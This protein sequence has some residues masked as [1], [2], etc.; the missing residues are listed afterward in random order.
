MGF[1][2]DDARRTPIRSLRLASDLPE[3]ERARLELLRTDGAT[4][5]ALVEARRNRRDA[6]YVAPAGRIDLC[7]VP[8]P[9]RPARAADRR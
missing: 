1:Y 5:A 4:F 3:A 9:V 2:D 7:S 8:L 6:W